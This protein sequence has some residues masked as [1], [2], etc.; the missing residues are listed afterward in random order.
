VD[1]EVEL[2]SVAQQERL[3]RDG[4]ADVALLHPPVRLDG[5]FDTRKL[6]TEGQVLLLPAGH[7]SP[8][9]PPDLRMADIPSSPACPPATAPC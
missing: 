8:A 9:A 7:R 1:V 6:R 4:R 2:C 3:L 5:R